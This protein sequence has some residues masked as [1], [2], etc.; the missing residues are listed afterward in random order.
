MAS[1]VSYK[2]QVCKTPHYKVNFL[3]KHCLQ[4]NVLCVLG[5]AGSQYFNYKHTNSLVLM[6]ICDATYRF[7]HVDIGDFGRHHDAGIFANSAMG[8]SLA[9]GTFGLPRPEILQGTNKM[10]DYCIIGDSAFPLT[11]YMMKPYPG[12]HL[13]DPEMIFNYRYSTLVQT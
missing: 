13:P 9:D 11:R 3:Y 10:V 2:H 8:S 6:A 12:S 5:N 7:L 1:I 4:V